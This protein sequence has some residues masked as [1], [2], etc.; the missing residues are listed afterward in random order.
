MR[1]IGV[2]DEQKQCNRCSF[3]CR[4]SIAYSSGQDLS[5]QEQD[6]EERSKKSFL[7]AY[8]RAMA[9]VL[10]CKTSKIDAEPYSYSSSV[11]QDK[12]RHS[13]FMLSNRHIGI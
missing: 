12:E 11:T 8:E 1:L 10:S 5:F 13:Q 4:R 6:F 9:S 2:L 3:S 7:L